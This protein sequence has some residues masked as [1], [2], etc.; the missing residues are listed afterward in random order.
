MIT[1]STN[2]KNLLSREVL[3]AFYM[4]KLTDETEAIVVNST[5]FFSNIILSNNGATLPTEIYEAD[6]RLVS[7]DAPQMST[8]LD[9]EQY[10]VVLNVFETDTASFGILAAM[11][12]GLIGKNLVCRIGFVNPDTGAPYLDVS[13]TIIVYKGRVDSA[14]YNLKTDN[15]GEAQLLI[16]GSS[17]MRSLDMKKSLY[18]S[19]DFIR[20]TNPTDSCC[21]Q[22]YSG[23]GAL[24]FKWGRT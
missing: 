24:R 21:D 16:T 17:P 22:I 10:R 11:E 2:V 9:R 23:S 13:D 1:L 4:L 18:L 8:T 12:Q 7:V 3:E 15:I 14:S 20:K 6:G 5:S 19:R